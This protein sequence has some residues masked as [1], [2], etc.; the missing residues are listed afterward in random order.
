M[1]DGSKDIFAVASGSFSETEQKW[2]TNEHEA[3]GIHNTLMA[4]R[5]YLLGLHR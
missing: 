3:K 5:N 4:F 1:N 2:S